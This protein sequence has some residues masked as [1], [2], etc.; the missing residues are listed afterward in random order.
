MESNSFFRKGKLAHAL[1]IRCARNTDIRNVKKNWNKRY[2]SG[3]QIVYGN[4]R[5]KMIMF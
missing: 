4:S 5:V 3:G 1:W 2:C